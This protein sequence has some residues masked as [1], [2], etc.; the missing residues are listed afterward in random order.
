MQA[1]HAARSGLLLRALVGR[2]HTLSRGK[3]AYGLGPVRRVLFAGALNE[4]SQ[5]GDA[6]GVWPG[7][8]ALL[9]GTRCP[10]QRPAPL[11]AGRVTAA[12]LTETTPSAEY[13]VQQDHLLCV[14]AL[15]LVPP[16]AAALKGK[17]EKSLSMIEELMQEITREGF[18][19]AAVTH[20]AGASPVA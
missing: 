1:M 17:V 15:S 8:G 14:K 10:P 2:R 7:E 11:E 20:V 6:G 3:S 12:A 16:P 13:T 18:I 9:A 19:Q 4:D 5:A